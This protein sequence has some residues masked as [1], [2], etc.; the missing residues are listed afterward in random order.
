MGIAL[1]FATGAFLFATYLEIFLYDKLGSAT[2]DQK[3]NFGY[4][5]APHTTHG[6]MGCSLGTFIFLCIGVGPG[7]GVLSIVYT[8]FFGFVVIGTMTLFPHTMQWLNRALV[9]F[10]YSYF[11]Y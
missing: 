10:L 8:I 2:D 7:F 1:F 9:T 4:E 5:D 11:L 3:K 6:I